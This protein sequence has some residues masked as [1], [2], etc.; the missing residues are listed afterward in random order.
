M[1]TRQEL[2][3][4]T[5]LR[6][7]A[8]QDEQALAQFYDRYARLVYALCLKSLAA[9]EDAEEVVLDVFGQVWR[10]AASYDPG[11][12]RVEAW[13]IQI[14]RSRAI[15][16][17]RRLERQGRAQASSEEN[18]H[19]MPMVEIHG[20]ESDVILSERTQEMVLAL[21]QLPEAQRRAIELAYYKGLSHTEIAS[22]TGESL[23]TIKTRIRLGLGKLREALAPWWGD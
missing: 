6:R 10:T 22:A 3:E 13:L 9:R 1:D 16:R 2:D 21:G 12:G 18:A 8:A 7:I 14:A 19:Q 5:L 17:Y 23:G 11:R 20:P 4:V 15:D